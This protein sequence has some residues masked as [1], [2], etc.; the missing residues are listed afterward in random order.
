M[1]NRELIRTKVIQLGYAYY[2]NGQ[3]DPDKAE[4]EL[5]LS[6]SK[7]YELYN[8]LLALIIAITKE[9]RL[10]VEI[11]AN[12]A[13]REHKEEPSTRFAFNK[14][15]LQLEENLQLSQFLTQYG[16]TWDDDIDIVRRLC[17]MIE[18]SKPY[19]DFM[20]S[21]D[22]SY[23]AHRAVWRKLY[24]IAILD[25]SDIDTVLEE[26]SIYWNDDKAVIDTF[27]MKT[28]NRFDPENGE[29]Q[30]LLTDYD[31]EEDRSFAC[32]LLRSSLTHAEEYQSYMSDVSRNWDFS[33]LAAMDVVIMQT[34]IAEMLNIPNIPVNVTINEYVELAK[35]Y[36][37]PKSASYINGMLD[38]IGRELKASGKM[39]K[40]M[41]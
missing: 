25:N 31:S 30:Q 12:R 39:I 32:K 28:I 34:A 35:N 6:L 33:R 37:T 20:Q 5:L 17:D 24:R 16:L 2:H 38:A 3:T 14:F 40:P 9:E 19:Q 27:V 1:I 26:K 41:K 7:A 29:E 15:A 4:K 36:S 13:K 23:D 10:R 18:S 11:A 22:D 21:D 8:F